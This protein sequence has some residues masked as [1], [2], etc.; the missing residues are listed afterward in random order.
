[1][2]ARV[3]GRGSPAPG[4]GAARVLRLIPCRGLLG[5]LHSTL[6]S[7][8]PAPEVYRK[9]TPHEHVLLRPGMT[10]D[11]LK[12]STRRT[13]TKQFKP[14]LDKTKRTPG[15]VRTVLF[16]SLLVGAAALPALIQNPVVLAKL[17]EL[18]S[19]DRAGF[20]PIEVYEQTGRFIP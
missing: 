7:E 11:E 12:S 16:S 8:P 13:P 15:T 4:P 18:A 17:I 1:M 5:R 20:T 2:L 14:T 19:L 10:Y 9:L 6:P 3:I